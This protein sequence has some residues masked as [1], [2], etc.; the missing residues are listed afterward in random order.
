[1]K[2]DRASAA[3]ASRP[4]LGWSRSSWTKAM[5]FVACWAG[6]LLGLAAGDGEPTLPPSVPA[7]ASI[8]VSPSARSTV[9]ST[10]GSAADAGP[11]TQSPAVSSV[12]S[13][14]PSSGRDAGGDPI[15]QESWPV[16]RFMNQLAEAVQHGSQESRVSCEVVSQSES[17]SEFYVVQATRGEKSGRLVFCRSEIEQENMRQTLEKGGV[18]NQKRLELLQNGTSLLVRAPE[19]RLEGV[20]E[21]LSANLLQ[22]PDAR[23]LQELLLSF[24]KEEIEVIRITGGHEPGYSVTLRRIFALD[25]QTSGL[26]RMHID[27]DKLRVRQMTFL[28]NV[29]VED[30]KRNWQAPLRVHMRLMWGDD[31]GFGAVVDLLENDKPSEALPDGSG[32]A[33]V[34]VHSRIGQ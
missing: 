2:L 22:L 27:P 32:Y 7:V 30:P 15:V 25:S 5:S 20:Y 13:P 1:M 14:L 28:G 29:R 17:G 21:G 34:R 24:V 10:S 4:E 31:P 3:S 12:G 9:T 26:I 19:S 6:L 33:R 11:G 23:W 16:D 18:D 8:P